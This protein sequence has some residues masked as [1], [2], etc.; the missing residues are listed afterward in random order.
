MCLL[1]QNQILLAMYEHVLMGNLTMVS[2]Q[3]HSK[4]DI[5]A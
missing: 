2:L 3:Y 1:I 4:R 5:L